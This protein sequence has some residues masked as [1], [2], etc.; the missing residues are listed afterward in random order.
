MQLCSRLENIVNQNTMKNEMARTLEDV[1]SRRTRSLILNARA[2]LEV[3]PAVA[4]LMAE[5]LGRDGDWIDTQVED[6]RKVAREYLA[7]VS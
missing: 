1:L 7:E 3:A 5:E 2:S 4:E 6:Y